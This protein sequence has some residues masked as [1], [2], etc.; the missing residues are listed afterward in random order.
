MDSYVHHLRDQVQRHGDQRWLAFVDHRRG[1]MVET[2]RLTHGELDARAQAIGAW[3]H[4]RRLTDRPVLLLYPPGLEFLSAFVG[5]LYARCV[6]VPAPLPSMDAG[7]L[8]RAEKVI[9]DTRAGLVLTDAAHVEGLRAWLREAGL[10]ERVGCAASDA[11][12]RPV[13][14]A[15]PMPALGPQTLAYLQYT[16]GS[17]S[18]PRGVMV[19]HGNLLDNCRAISGVAVGASPGTAPLTNAGWLPHFHDMGLVGQWL[20]PLY[21][22]GDIA[23]TSPSSFLARPALWLQM[24]SHYR[25]R[26]TGAPNFAFDWLADRVGDQQLD[27]LDLSCL[28]WILN[29]AE[30]IRP[31]TLRRITRRLGPAGFR[32]EVWAPAYGLAEGTLMITGTTRGRGPVVTR[33]DHAALQQHRVVHAD[34]GVE[35]VSSGRSVSGDLRIVDPRERTEVPA[36]QVGEIWVSG[37]SVTLGYWQRPEAT[38]DT[39]HARLR[40]GRGP[41]LRTGDLGFVLDGELYVTGRRKDLIIFNGRNLYPQDLEEIG[42][43][44]HAAADAAAAFEVEH[45]GEPGGEGEQVVLVQEVQ[46]HRLAPLSLGELADRIRREL[47]GSFGLSCQVVLV[48]RNSIPRTTSGKI[49]RRLARELFLTGG[50]SV[51]HT[52]QDTGQ[53]T[54]VGPRADH[55]TALHDDRPADAIVAGS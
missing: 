42:R 46:P 7:A 35:L 50:L 25:A 10:A 6:A 36:G 18:E 1:T 26:F 9:Q 34:D 11:A 19:S 2:H 37:P 40:D 21:A 44:V 43:Q 33:V 20:T 54:G 5:C 24:I 22:G 13:P 3:L 32:P 30:P 17:T 31:A 4:D 52:G 39:F 47:V 8:V 38:R 48:R 49:Q 14:A 51:L 29:G 12:A 15:W 27:G 55:R 16:S 41:F 28:Q 53:D 45:P 23:V